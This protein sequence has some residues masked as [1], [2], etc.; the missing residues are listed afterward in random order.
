[1]LSCSSRSLSGGPAGPILATIP[2]GR[3]PVGN[4]MFAVSVWHRLGHHNPANMA[5]RHA[6][7][8]QE[9]LPKQIMQA[10]KRGQP[11]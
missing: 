9:L 6:N 4:D 2:V 5:P 3:M 10:P 8:L 11:R 7:A 1:M